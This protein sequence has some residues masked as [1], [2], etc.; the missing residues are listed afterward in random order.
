MKLHYSTHL[1]E[2]YWAKTQDF[3]Q[4]SIARNLAGKVDLILTSPPYPLAAPK[5]YGNKNG[6]EYRSDLLD[7]FMQAAPLLSEKGSLI[8]EIGNA[9]EKGLPE[10][11]TLPIE[12]LLSIKRDLNLVLCQ[13][14]IWDNPNKM[15]G[16]ANWVNIKRIRVK[17]SF[18]HIWW[19]SKGPFPK[20]DNRNVLAPYK[21]GM[22]KLL[23][24]QKYNRGT[25]P[26][27]H[28]VGDGF[29]VRNEGAIPSSVLRFS[30][31][32]E[33][34]AYKAWCEERGLNRHP[35]RMPADLAKF[36]INLTTNEGDLVFDPFGGSNTTGRAAEDLGRR[37]II[38]EMSEKYIEG[39]RGRF[40]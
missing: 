3:L 26:S 15:P 12:T 10:M 38:T 39:S 9:W 24:T 31:S 32:K 34:S 1:G 29:L 33:S 8:V 22:E 6:E 40:Q 19:F 30:N 11:Q 25:R 13:M 37:W 4:S 35:A 36:F 18:T 14:F 23:A 2:A 21:T 16:P 5:A 20:A 17:D 28:A 27:G 7:I